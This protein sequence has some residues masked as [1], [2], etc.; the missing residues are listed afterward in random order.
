M[1][2]SKYGIIY[3]EAGAQDIILEL[4]IHFF[5]HGCVAMKSEMYKTTILP[6]LSLKGQWS[7]NINVKISKEGSAQRG[8]QWRNKN[9]KKERWIM[10]R[11]SV[12]TIH[13]AWLG[14]HM[15]G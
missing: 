8:N 1:S 14:V 7:I 9:N 12:L 2:G 13:Q 6:W 11:K 10:G 3:S 15:G 4:S 5:Q